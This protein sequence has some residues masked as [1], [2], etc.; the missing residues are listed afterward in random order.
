MLISVGRKSKLIPNFFEICG[1]YAVILK[2]LLRHV[3]SVANSG[4]EVCFN[5]IKTSA[6]KTRARL[7]YFFDRPLMPNILK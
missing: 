1:V 7:L 6:R 2:S 5:T 3:L 4:I